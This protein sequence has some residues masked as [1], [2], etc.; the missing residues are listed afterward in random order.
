[1][2]QFIEFPT[3][4]QD[5]VPALMACFGSMPKAGESFK[6]FRRRLKAHGLWSRERLDVLLRFMQ[7]ASGDWVVPSTFAEALGGDD[8]PRA[9]LNRLWAVN[10]LL[11]A[12]V[13]ERLTE[14]IHSTNE[15]LK[16][17]DSFAY[18]GARIAGPDLRAWLRLADG[19]GL[20]K[21]VGIRMG[22]AD[23]AQ[24]AFARRVERF[25]VEE[26]LEDDEDEPPVRPAAVPADQAA[27]VDGAVDGAAVDGAVADEADPT[28]PADPP[29]ST[30]AATAV[31]ASASAAA[32]TVSGPATAPAVQALAAAATPSALPA[33]PTGIMELGGQ[34]E[35]LRYV[36]T[37]A[38]ALGPQG[39]G[40]T[41][42]LFEEEPERAL[43]ELAVAANLRFRVAQPTQ[44]FEALRQAGVLEA[45]Y[46]GVPLMGP[47]QVDA[48]ALMM[49]SLVARR[50]A[51]R[52]DLAF[53]IEQADN[54][55]AVHALLAKTFEGLFT[56]EP[57]WMIC[58]LVE[59]GV[60]RPGEAGDFGAL[61]MRVLATLLFQLGFVVL[62]GEPDASA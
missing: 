10:P 14:R 47:V 28:P 48:S 15:L 25:D 29:V 46:R 21:A 19:G 44:L 31:S 43:F 11:F 4:P 18:A 55:D 60:V 16:Y 56:L 59:L 45:L 13:V 37:A 35:H 27:V 50:L 6:N 38:G 36:P 7:M 54:A 8:G 53:E 62:P 40:L 52:A 23:E 26:F 24:E 17:V 12:T 1:M 3:L 22:L 58:A 2:P 33:G 34:L 32:P 30:V 49:A 39:F 61:S 9:V 57:C 5:G 51:Q 42:A 20:F 41:R